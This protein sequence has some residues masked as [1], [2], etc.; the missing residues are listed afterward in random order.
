LSA[1]EKKANVMRNRLIKKSKRGPI[2]RS[3]AA[4]STT[5]LPAKPGTTAGSKILK[6]VVKGVQGHHKVKPMAISSVSGRQYYDEKDRQ[7]LARMK[8]V[9][10]DWT[11]KEDRFILCAFLASVLFVPRYNHQ[12]IFTFNAPQIRDLLHSVLEDEISEQNIAGN[13]SAS[14]FLDEEARIL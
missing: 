2:G 4:V 8:R 3:V 7:A 12:K 13:S 6:K 14:P 1:E 10:V 9:R 11:P 5:K